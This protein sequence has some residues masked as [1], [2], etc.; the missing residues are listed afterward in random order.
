MIK[1]IS[2]KGHT[3]MA[4]HEVPG[5]VLKPH[6]LK[7]YND[8]KRGGEKNTIGLGHLLRRGVDDWMLDG[9]SYEQAHD[10]YRR[11][12]GWVEERLNG[13]PDVGLEQHHYDCLADFIFNIG[14]PEYAT[15]GVR[16]AVMSKPLTASYVP[17]QMA[18]WT[19]GHGERSEVL[20][21]R[22]CASALLWHFAK[23]EPYAD[24]KE[25]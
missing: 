14:W 19:R 15:S 5:G 4:Y 9:I 17:S 25:V 23:Y 8:G 12:Y 24:R 22:R 6:H 7:P 2:A 1:S 3:Y 16:E 13:E 18:L 11:D 10:I 21:R 20:I